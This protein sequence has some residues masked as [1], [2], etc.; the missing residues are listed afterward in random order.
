V[1][2]R[3][4]NLK[5]T[6][7]NSAELT[8]YGV[9]SQ[10]SWWGDEVTPKQFSDDLKALGDDIE[11]ITVR[12]N[13]DG[14]DVF[15]GIAIHN[16]LKRHKAKVIV[17]VDGL[18]ASIASIIAMAG[19]KVIMP[20][21]SMMMIHNPWTS[22]WGGD[23]DDFRHTA[24]ILDK[25]RDSLVDVYA[26]K[27]KLDKEEIKALLDA[28]TWMTA[29]E[30][31]AKGFADEVEGTIS[32]A[33][34]IRGKMAIINGVQVDW[35]KFKNAP[36][37]PEE[38]PEQPE[39]PEGEEHDDSTTNSTATLQPFNLT[40]DILAKDFPDVYAAAVQKGIEQERARMKAIDDLGILGYKDLVAK[41]KYETGVSAEQLLMEVWKA[42]QQQRQKY[43][44]AVQ[45]DAQESGV[46]DVLADDP[47]PPSEEED[48]QTK[49]QAIANYI[50]KLRGGNK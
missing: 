20:K 12:I 7:K 35:S 19:D 45:Q 44:N 6:T 27:T 1:K 34:S 40:I 36:P 2:K 25:I 14:G 15:A 33:A 30:A 22:V 42:Q 11:E 18:A 13:S 16:M 17:Y 4:W 32:V 41:A 23:A 21:G 37:L 28:E 38:A 3:F 49:A 48:T 46:D 26:E 50:N 10:D 39:E 31:V 8:L 47:T 5:Q 29:E 43:L 24:D 9:I